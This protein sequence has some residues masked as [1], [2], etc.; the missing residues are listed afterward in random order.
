[1]SFSDLIL[2][3][4]DGH[5]SRTASR[6]AKLTGVSPAEISAILH[7]RIPTMDIAARLGSVLPVDPILMLIRNS[8]PAHQKFFDR[9]L[10]RQSVAV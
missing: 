7:G 6:L 4:I 2:H 3:W 9:I 5:P 10:S 8:D 1:M